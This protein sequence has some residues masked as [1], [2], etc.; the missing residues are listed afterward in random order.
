MMRKTAADGYQDATQD[1]LLGR[2]TPTVP[3]LAT[4]LHAPGVR[5][6][7]CRGYL[8]CLHDAGAINLGVFEKVMQRLVAMDPIRRQKWI[9]LYLP[10]S[11]DEENLPTRRAFCAF[12]DALETSRLDPALT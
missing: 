2:L 9:A 4:R 6:A 10:D 5:A 1:W 11:W 3:A 8:W 7:Y 12:L